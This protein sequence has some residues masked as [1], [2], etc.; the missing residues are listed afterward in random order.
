[1][2]CNHDGSR[3]HAAF[4]YD[5][6][7]L[8]ASDRFRIDPTL[9]LVGGPQFRARQADGTVFH[10]IIADSEPDGWAAK[11]ILRDHA[12]RRVAARL[13]NEQIPPLVGRLDFLLA[14]DDFSR[15][16]ALRYRDEQSVFQRDARGAE[17]TAP[18][19]LELRHLLASSRAVEMNNETAHDLEYLRGR[20]TSLGGMRPKCTILDADGS[21][22]IGKFP[23]VHDE[24]AYTKGEVLALRLAAESGINAAQA[25]IEMSDDIPVAIVKR[26]DR[27]D[28][29]RLMYASAATLMGASTN[30]T[31]EYAYTDIVDTIRQRSAD[32]A[33]DIEELWR[34]MA[35]SV[36]ITNVDDHLHNHGFLHVQG[37]TWRLSPA[38]D[39]NPF[40][41]RVRELK[42]W[43]SDNAGPAATVDGLMSVLAY[44]NL[45]L[46]RARAM[47]AQV[48]VA[49]S[50]WRD[51]GRS[52][53]MTRT[54][55][56]QFADAFE[57]R[58]RDTAR[59]EAAR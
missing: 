51:V 26:F 50:R 42:T 47:L 53:A 29:R 46:A 12:K 38:F 33:S 30:D 1:M 35:F 8:S 15:V 21:L 7:W 32:A 54:E 31:R 22:A 27:R 14:V 11:V 37:E 20:G 59:L 34:R 10:S 55:L 19:L 28:T 56:D 40:P 3:E 36:L 52:L 13:A 39:I 44:F 23:S 16:G 6:T 25:R 17:R 49:V 43:I 58:E 2:L 4:E 24:R 18:P 57:H 48:E 45:K 41:D 5:A 9:P